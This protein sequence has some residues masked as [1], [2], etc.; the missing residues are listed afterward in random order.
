MDQPTK[1]ADE[2]AKDNPLN[3]PMSPLVKSSIMSGLGF[4]FILY[5][6][7][8]EIL[9]ALLVAAITFPIFYY[10]FWKTQVLIKKKEAQQREKA[11]Q[12][13]ATQTDAASDGQ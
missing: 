12:E 2:A 3:K 4:A 7:D 10:I 13:E 6:S 9:R 5:R 8:G 11:A 1:S